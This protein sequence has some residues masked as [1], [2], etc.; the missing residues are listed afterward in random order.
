MIARSSKAMVALRDTMAKFSPA[1]KVEPNEMVGPDRVFTPES[2]RSVLDLNRQ[3]VVGNRG[4]GKSL[5]THALLDVDVRNRVAAVYNQPQLKKTEVLI[6]FNG[7]EKALPIAPTP[8]AIEQVLS[9]G[10]SPEDVWRAVIYRAVTIIGQKSKTVPF[11]DTLRALSKKPSDFEE[12][13]SNFDDHLAVSNQNFLILFDALDRLP[14]DWRDIRQL[15]TALLRRSVGL[16]SFRSIRTKT[17]IRPDQ[18]ADKSMFQFPDG[19]KIRNDHVDLS[20]KPYELFGLLFFEIMRS[21]NGKA[22]LELVAQEVGAVGALGLS[23]RRSRNSPED[24]KKIIDAIAGPFM[25]SNARRGRVYTWVPLHLSDAQDTCSPRTFL[26][27]WQMASEHQPVPTGRAVDH[28]GLIE[29][30]RKASSTR[31]AELREDYRWI[32]GALAAL[33]GQ[34]VPIERSEVIQIW[35]DSKVVQSILRDAK[36]GSWLAPVQLADSEEPAA[37][38]DAMNS[39]AVTEERANGKINVPDIFRVEA[40]I[41]RRGGVAVPRRA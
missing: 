6:G 34:F 21:G 37:L 13:V 41:K 23:T 15:T 16:K 7:S 39:I 19:S 26:T 11:T 8:K 5:W 10:H 33:K 31:L 32:D 22:A 9:E 29:G 14:G 1:S 30:V 27:A 28:L 25:G 18:F 35:N 2:H 40:G 4:M 20:W 17:F 3:L 38:L 12:A 24:Q 36:L